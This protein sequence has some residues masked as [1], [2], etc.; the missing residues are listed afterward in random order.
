MQR[1]N[2]LA[3]LESFL[4]VILEHVWLVYLTI[5]FWHRFAYRAYKKNTYAR[6]N[7]H[8]PVQGESF[9]ITFTF[10]HHTYQVII[11]INTS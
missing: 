4:W 2:P 7:K 3:L 9:T 8:T 1:E 10:I 11:L 6:I 5:H